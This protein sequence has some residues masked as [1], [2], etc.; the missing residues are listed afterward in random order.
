MISLYRRIAGCRLPPHV[1]S[2][3]P[4]PAE[5]SEGEKAIWNKLN[6]KFSPS[7]LKVMDV[8]GGCGSFYNIIIASENFKGI[9]TVKQHRMVNEILKQEIEGIHGLQLK[10]IVPS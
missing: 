8:S 10:T 1:R 2:Y 6:E 3:I 4:T 7:E 5:L 9:P